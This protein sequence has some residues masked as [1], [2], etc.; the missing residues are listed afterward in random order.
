MPA[1]TPGSPYKKGSGPEGK[2][3]WSD[4]AILTI[5]GEDVL[6]SQILQKHMTLWNDGEG[7]L[8]KWGDLKL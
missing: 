6:L 3:A 4:T 7:P 2:A 8:C 1:A 5:C